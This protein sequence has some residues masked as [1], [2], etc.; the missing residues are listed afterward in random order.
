MDDRWIKVI[1][2]LCIAI[3]VMASLVIFYYPHDT[4]ASLAEKVIIIP[5]DINETGWRF[6]IEI[7]GYPDVSGALSTR[8]VEIDKDSLH[9]VNFVGT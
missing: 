7:D 6:F 2:I 5:E 1:S 8:T 9:V 4:E 3:I